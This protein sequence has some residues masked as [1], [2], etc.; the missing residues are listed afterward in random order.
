MVKSNNWFRLFKR[1]I[2]GAPVKQ[3]KEGYVS[4]SRKGRTIHATQSFVE[5]NTKHKNAAM[6]V[7]RFIRKNK[8]A[9]DEGKKLM[10]GKINAIVSREFTGQYAG[11]RNVGT[12]KV[13]FA[14]KLF[15]VKFSSTRK[16]P[17]ADYEK[18]RN[19]LKKI[20]YKYNG[21]NFVVLMPHVIYVPQKGNR[22]PV[23]VSDFVPSEGTIQ[24]HTGTKRIFLEKKE[25]TALGKARELFQREG[26]SNMELAGHNIFYHEESKTF[27]LFDPTTPY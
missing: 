25:E 27:F 4:S 10:D 3:I 26:L 18:A 12:Y 2:K 22:A 17:L 14:G 8:K 7:L 1:P 9:L 21:F 15:F 23:I 13:D 19:A 16:D 24:L 11:N 6:L 20:N 5:F